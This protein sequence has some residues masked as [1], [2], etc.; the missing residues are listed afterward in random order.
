MTPQEGQANKELW[1]FVSDWATKNGQLKSYAW[2]GLAEAVDL[3]AREEML[4]KVEKLIPF[5]SACTSG[6]C[7]RCQF[8]KLKERELK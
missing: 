3:R 5:H 8:E 2:M 1:A 7:V 4:E 6:Y